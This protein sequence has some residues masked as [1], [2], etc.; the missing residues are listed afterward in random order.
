VPVLSLE[1]LQEAK[2]DVENIYVHTCVLEYMVDLVAATRAG[3]NVVMGVSPRGT[4]AFL[5]CV[6]AYAYLQGR[7]YATPDD[8]KTLAVPV[9]AHRVIMGYG[10]AGE[11]KA[12]VEKL[13]GSIAVPTEDFSA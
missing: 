6:K 10:K 13:V 8:V 2:R 11:N 3:E 7:S 12:F 1:N 4:L 5:R 9:L